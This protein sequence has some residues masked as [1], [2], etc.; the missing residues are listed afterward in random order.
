MSVQQR[1]Y[2][3]ESQYRIIVFWTA[4][5]I[6]SGSLMLLTSYITEYYV[7]FYFFNGKVF[8]NP[9]HWS[10]FN[11]ENF[12]RSVQVEHV[13]SSGLVPS[14]SPQLA[15]KQWLRT[16]VWLWHFKCS[17]IVSRLKVTVSLQGEYVVFVQIENHCISDLKVVASWRV[18]V[19]EITVASVISQKLLK[20]TIL[21]WSWKQHNWYR[22]TA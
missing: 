9:D 7:E 3:K 2:L 22:V 19:L 8:K 17:V 6:W 1:S 4:H 10:G 16:T 18:F 12:P 15:M 14:G 21:L 11:L 5:C 13:L 20:C